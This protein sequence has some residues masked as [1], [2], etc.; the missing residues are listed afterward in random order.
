MTLS[1][2]AEAKSRLDAYLDAV[3]QTL[4]R[5]GNARDQ[6]RA[7]VDD[8]ETHIRD[9]LAARTAKPTLADIEAVL[10]QMDPVTAYGT[11]LPTADPNPNPSADGATQSVTS[12]ALY[13][14]LACVA[15]AALFALVLGA[16]WAI[17]RF[18]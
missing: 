11:P 6:R 7:I 1:L 17:R 12:V 10:A 9:L 2:S 16:M 14:F 4:H 5:S 13:F 3:E 8:L 18:G 15:F